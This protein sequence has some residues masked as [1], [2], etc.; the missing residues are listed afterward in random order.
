[1]SE[2]SQIFQGDRPP[3]RT[4]AAPEASVRKPAPVTVPA[5]AAEPMPTVAEAARTDEPP[6][7]VAAPTAAPVPQPELQLQVDESSLWH[8][9]T[10]LQQRIANL[11]STSAAT[12]HL[13]D[14]QEEAS[15]K[16]AQHLKVLKSL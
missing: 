15:R 10:T 4:S 5:A 3:Q 7:P 13:L 16:I 12:A 9:P 1:M 2:D 11:Q 6:V 8:A 14:E